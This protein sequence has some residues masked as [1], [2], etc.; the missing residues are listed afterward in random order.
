[1]PIT[2]A[3]LRAAGLKAEQI[4]RI[5]ELAEQDKHEQLRAKWR[6]DKRR[7]RDRQPVDKSGG[8]SAEMSTKMS[9]VH[10]DKVDPQTPTLKK[11][12]P[13]RLEPYGSNL[14]GRAQPTKRRLPIDFKLSQADIA[15]A[16]SKGLSAADLQDQFERFCDHWQGNGAT[17][18]DWSA[19]WR[20]WVRRSFEFNRKSNAGQNGHGRQQ[21]ETIPERTKRLADACRRREQ[22]ISEGLFGTPHND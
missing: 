19:T 12:L 11:D 22:E 14:S 2:I 10:V 3:H 7:Q 9:T 13:S 21:A 20:N 5:C 16:Q 6:A 8:Q 18:S 17:K 4:T 1:M 15:F